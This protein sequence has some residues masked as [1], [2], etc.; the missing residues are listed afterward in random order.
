MK[1]SS[2]VTIALCATAL[3]GVVIW[4]AVEHQDRLRLA[5]E[6]N[7]LRQKLGAMAG[8]VAENERLS[9]LVAQANRPSSLPNEPVQPQ[10]L[11]D[12]RLKE[13]LRLRG[14]VRVHR[15]QAKELDALREDTLQARAARQGSFKPHPPGQAATTD[16]GTASQPSQLEI[17][18]AEYWT[19]N[20]RM[21][22]TGELKDR[23]RGDSLK[24]VASND[25][26]GDPEFGQTK[27]LTVEYKFGGVTM[28]NEF[29]EGDVIALPRE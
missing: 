3:V 2:L 10:S 12:E 11:P 7:A 18:K 6:N 26:K 8:L 9:N 4:L 28:T 17:L 24:A 29:R 16:N 21:D 14:E 13:L 23:I 22:V 27:R 25:I 19:D 15:Q 5:D 1:A 20:A